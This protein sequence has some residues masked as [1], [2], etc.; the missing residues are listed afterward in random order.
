MSTVKIRAGSLFHTPG[1]RIGPMG[2]AFRPR[3]ERFP[4]PSTGAF[5]RSQDVHSQS[6]IA[7]CANDTRGFKVEQT[8]LCRGEGR[9]GSAPRTLS[10]AK[11]SVSLASIT[12]EDEEVK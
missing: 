7:S 5:L 4:P 1:A 12:L 6:A 3:R 11:G 8:R 10:E 9:I 2:A